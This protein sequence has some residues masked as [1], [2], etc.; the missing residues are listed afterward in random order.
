MKYNKD[1]ILMLRNA[2]VES[3]AKDYINTKTYI[4]KHPYQPCTAQKS[5]LERLANWFRSSKY[6]DMDLGISGDYILKKLDEMVENNVKPIRR[7]VGKPHN[8]KV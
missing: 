3:V 8:R 5:E 4:L 2:I 7:R 1:G 6:D